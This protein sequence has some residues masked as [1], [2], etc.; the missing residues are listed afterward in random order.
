MAKRNTGVRAN[1]RGVEL[2][3]EIDDSP[4]P[5]AQELEKYNSVS[6]EVLPFILRVAEKE[7]QYRHDINSR[8][9]TEV[10]QDGIRTFKLNKTGLILAFIICMSGFLLGTW[11]IYK[12]KT[13]E[14]SIFAGT[15]FVLIISRFI[16]QHKREHNQT[17]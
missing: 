2:R 8:S 14:G 1:N 7:Q 9:M 11:L 3:E 13:I 12:G 17:K 15:T 6:P 10:E 4:L 16:G 5:S